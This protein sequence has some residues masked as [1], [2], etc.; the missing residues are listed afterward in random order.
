MGLNYEGRGA[1]VKRCTECQ[2]PV[3]ACICGYRPRLPSGCSFWILT[4]RKEF[5]KPSNSARL[6]GACLPDVRFFRW[7]RTEPDA[8]LLALLEDARYRPVL[9]FPRE[10][11]PLNPRSAAFSEKGAG[12]RAFL[13]LDGTWQQALKIYR[14]SPYL[15]G[16]PLLSLEPESPSSYGLRRSRSDRQLC[17]AEVAVELLR[18]EGELESATQ[19]QNY[20]RVFCHAYLEARNHREPGCLPEMDALLAYRAER[21]D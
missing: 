18:G 16:L 9:V 20:F 1:G 5:F 7:Q 2:L 10:M 17:T 11:A 13:L 21:P 12:R 8:E 14:K 4:H 15:H 3:G 6:I 19:L